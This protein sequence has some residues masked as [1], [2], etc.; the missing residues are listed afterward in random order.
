MSVWGDF[1]TKI[2]GVYYGEDAAED[3]DPLAWYHY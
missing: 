2:K 3:A 1:F